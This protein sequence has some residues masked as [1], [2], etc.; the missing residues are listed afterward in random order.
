M[1]L[2]SRLFRGDPKL[3]AAAVSDPAHVFQ[4]ANGPHVAKIQQALNQ[5][6]GAGLAQDGIYG[7]RTAGAVAAF[8]QKRQI[9]NFQ[10][11]IDSIVGKKTTAALDAE[12]LAKERGTAPAP[13]PRPLTES[14]LL[15]CPH[16]A[17][18]QAVGGPF[19]TL[20]PAQRILTITHVYVITSCPLRIDRFDV[21]PVTPCFTVLWSKFNPRVLVSGV[22]TLDV[23]SFGLCVGAVF[24]VPNGPVFI[25]SP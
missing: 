21:S 10:G 18:I 5:L 20:P 25:A 11:R 14:S 3:E 22:P 24:G 2:Q 7:P 4:G 15:L 19:S 12:M 17:R 9:L 23:T 1:A 8:K 13:E 6:D 16:G